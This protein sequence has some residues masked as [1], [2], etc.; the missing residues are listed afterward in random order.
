MTTLHAI[1]LD[2]RDQEEASRGARILVKMPRKASDAWSE[3]Q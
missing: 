3:K 2:A 1:W